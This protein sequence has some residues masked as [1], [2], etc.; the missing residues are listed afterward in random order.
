MKTRKLLFIIA[1]LCFLNACAKR[2][3]LMPE[4]NHVQIILE[5]K[6]NLPSKCRPIDEI[7]AFVNHVDFGVDAFGAREMYAKDYEILIK[8]KAHSLGG[9]TA[10]LLHRVHD[11]GVYF[12]IY[13]IYNCA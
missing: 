6:K 5:K 9:N 10:E 3:T 7:A 12:D 1:L 11:G 4:A 13:V 2:P 8:N